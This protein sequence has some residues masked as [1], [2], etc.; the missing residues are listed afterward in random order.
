MFKINK[1]SVVVFNQ[2]STLYPTTVVLLLIS[3][4]ITGLE[5]RSK[6]LSS[7]SDAATFANIS[8]PVF[9]FKV[10]EKYSSII[11]LF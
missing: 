2:G 10:A 4:I 7:S 8:Y 11:P 1:S 9:N 6:V 3:D 5:T